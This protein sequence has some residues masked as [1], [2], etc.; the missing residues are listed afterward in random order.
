MIDNFLEE[1]YQSYNKVYSHPQTN[2]CI[3]I[4]DFQSAIDTQFHQ[5]CNIKTSSH[6][7]K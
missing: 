4:G 5:K 2:S 7:A 6:N 1:E 3:Y